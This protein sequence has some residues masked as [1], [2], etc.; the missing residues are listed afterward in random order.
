M[1]AQFGLEDEAT[2]RDF[3]AKGSKAFVNAAEAKTKV[4]E[5]LATRNAPAPTAKP[6]A[7]AATAPTAA[8]PAKAPAV[9]KPAAPPPAAAAKPTAQQMGPAKDPAAAASVGTAMAGVEP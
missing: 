7:K 4:T 6:A 5:F 2:Y 3:V 9:A 8:A 1:A